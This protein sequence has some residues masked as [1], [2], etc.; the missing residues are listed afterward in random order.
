MHSSR[1]LFAAFF[2]A[3]FFAV[4]A[5]AAD[6]SPAGTWKWMQQGFQGGQGFE[7]K[8]TLELKDGKVTGKMHAGQSQMGELPEVEIKE[9]TFKDGVV[10]FSITRDIQGTSFTVKYS[11]KLD[12][13]TIKGSAEF[14]GFNGGEPTKR[15][16]EAKR[17][18]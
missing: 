15:D 5:F 12:G 11:G 1:K 6:A 13:D 10:A 9:G 7:R 3:C 14:P 4:A 17:D 18:K 2:A 16:W 8:I